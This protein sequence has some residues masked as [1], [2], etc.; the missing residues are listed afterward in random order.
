MP[1]SRSLPPG[2]LAALV[3]GA[4][5]LTSALLAWRM[6][7]E[8][9]NRDRLRFES[10]FTEL[11]RIA[12]RRLY[13]LEFAPRAAGALW[14]VKRGQV[15]RAEFAAYFRD[16][17]LLAELPGALGIGFVRRVPRAALEDFVA[18]TRAD[19]APEFKVKTLGDAAELHV[20]EFIEP[21][22]P[23]RAAL[24][25]DLAQDPA[26]RA[27][28]KNALLSGETAAT[29]HV[30][31][32]Q[33]PVAGPG[34]LLLHPVYT[35]G[36]P[37]ATPEARRTRLLGWIVLPLL[38]ERLFADVAREI[39]EAELE[40]DV[41]EDG[42][43]AAT[44]P[45][46]RHAHRS[47]ENHRPPALEQ[48][49]RLSLGDVNWRLVARPARNFRTES[50]LDVYTT[51]L[52]GIGLSLAFAFLI[53]RLRR[54]A[55]R[56]EQNAA[57]A[58]T[59]LSALVDDVRLLALVATRTT[60]A[61]VF[62]D[63]RRH[64]TWVNQGFTRMTGYEPAEVLGRAPGEILQNE[65]SDPA[66]IATMRAALGRGEPCKCEILNRKKDGAEY[67]VDLD[68]VPLRD[69]SGV[70]NGFMA[71]QSDVTTRKAAEDKL[72][73][74]ADR[75]ELALAAGEFGLWDWH[76]PSGRT[77]F[78]A[79]WA[80]ML[81]EDPA[82]LPPRIEEWSSR[83]HPDDLPLAEAAL[84]R[85]FDGETPLYQ[86]LHRM[87]HRDG[88]WRWIM[89][90]G[91]LVARTPRGEPMRMV[92][93][94]QDLTHQHLAR[95]SLERDATAFAHMGRLAQVGFWEVDL[96]AGTIFWSQQV[97]AIHEVPYD[98]VPN[99][100]TAMAFYPAE[101]ETEISRLFQ[102]TVERGD[103]FDVELPFVTARG[104]H[105]WVRA[106]GE[107]VRRNN[108]TVAVHGAFQDVTE[109][110]RQR[111][112]L[113]AARDAA[114]AAARAKADFLANMSHEIRTPINAVIGMT[115]LLQTTRLSPEQ[116]EFTD[117]V[118]TSSQSLLALINDILDFSKIEAGGL[119]LE[120]APLGLRDCAEHALDLVAGQGAA[121]NLELFITVEP[122]LPAGIL[123]DINRLR[124]IL[125]NLLGN[126]VKFTAEGEVELSIAAPPPQAGKP[127][128][129]RFTVRDT[130]IGIPAN[131]LDRLFKSFSQVDNSTT[132]VYGGTGLGLAISASL[133]A[134]MKGRI[135]VD[136]TPGR[137]SSFHV[138]IPLLPAPAPFP[139]PGL[140][141]ALLGRSV[142]VIAPHAGLR[143]QLVTRIDS[144]G[145]RAVAAE[146]GPAALARLEAG[147]SFDAA[148]LAATAS[149]PD[150]AA[151]AALLRRPP[152]ARALPLVLLAPRGAPLRG[153]GE[154]T[155]TRVV[156]KP[157]K[158]ALLLDALAQ[159]LRPTAPPP[160]PPAPPVAP[161]APAATR[162][163]PAPPSALRI[164]LAED[165]AVN[166]RVALL[167]L[168]TLGHTASVANHG[169][170]ALALVSRQPVDILFL[171]VQMPEMDGLT[172]ATRL[173]E[174]YP[175]ETRPWIIAMTANALEGDR[176]RCLA[177]GMDDYI[178]KPISG[179]AIS[180]AIERAVEGLAAR[181]RD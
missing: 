72:R 4:G 85:H 26:R 14:A 181:R 33:A 160:P 84:K 63:A 75:T 12:S 86:C 141:S 165:L 58:T 55:L 47:S 69:E 112:A 135:W 76:V 134:L 100:A 147:E 137:G 70:L 53:L 113:A 173:C 61:V 120:R 71:V 31:L 32:V 42:P 78:D 24:G 51:T 7:L 114:E 11:E 44:R 177:S 132:R 35:P 164:V 149:A 39:G 15:N 139:P 125:V 163:E 138:E 64:I 20:V 6:E 118:R 144:W 79:R 129:L 45:L 102:G 121:K 150:L 83:C 158:S 143:R 59:D 122:S 18:A 77:H 88:T 27:A 46:F 148:L 162:T 74:T 8:N 145:L 66:V 56:A 175:P 142:L 178:S 67:W 30:T 103:S 133:V 87:R 109:S 106:L 89:A 155:A 96:V 172:C 110:R 62:T 159:V 130:G 82:T 54:S 34:F 16:H 36:P 60:N 37:P 38:A 43:S 108:V 152:S 127:A 80:T 161:P 116:T 99:L 49:S 151:L 166:Q 50:R 170:E 90:C 131:R 13:Q 81:G 10:R 48:S 92:G 40:F 174:D 28:A 126:A 101:A 119:Q 17:D 107:V 105:R 25:L 57:A 22:E 21:A 3:F 153:F 176:E 117:T 29:R 98:Y 140:P 93:S 52:G 111:D 169:L 156:A 154:L 171:D 115:E 94:N 146:N 124:Q 19:Q 95:L 68:I 180:A 104:N 2:R 167:I 157:P 97:R 23:N 65:R 128:V 1:T 41:H 9:R 168:E 136:S 5:L 73:E 123:G 179:P 91:R